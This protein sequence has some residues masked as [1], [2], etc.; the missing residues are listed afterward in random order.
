M[1]GLADVQAAFTRVCFDEAPR[2]ADLAL[3]SDDRQRWLMYRRMVRH[4]LFE[5]AAAGL[6]RTAELLG[7]ERFRAAV[8]GCLAARGPRTRFIREIV[9]ELVEH[10]LEGW[11]ADPSLP[12]HLGDLVRYEEA[13][14]RVASAELDLPIA[15]DF[16]FEAAPVVNPTALALPL[17]HRVDK[18]P[19][20][21]PRLDEL[22][23]AIVYRKPESPRVFTYVLNEVGG[24][25]YAAWTSGQRCADGARDVLAA[26]GREP[27]AR[28]I[29]GLAGVLAELV[30]QKI[31]LGSAR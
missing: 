18:D 1:S 11:E 29:D 4:R 8:A 2:E 25:L 30:E 24:L 9:H 26:L 23:T 16:D 6:P 28:F 12:P 21:P 22:H 13:K 31:F 14:W 19:L 7:K 3:L 15:A 17:W 20:S 27:D 10:A 5:M